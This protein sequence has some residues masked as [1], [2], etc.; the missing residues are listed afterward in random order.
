MLG[1]GCQ[2]STSNQTNAYVFGL[3]E[4]TRGTTTMSAGGDEMK[5]IFIAF[6]AY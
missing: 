3:W 6:I 5:R 4:E 1:I 2:P